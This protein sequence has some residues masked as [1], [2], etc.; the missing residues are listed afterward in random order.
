[1]ITSPRALFAACSVA[2]VLSLAA[3]AQTISPAPATAA[4][5]VEKPVTLSPFVLIEDQDGGYA[6]HETLSGTRLRTPVKDVASAMTIVTA[7][8]MRDLGALN[9]NDVLD[10]IPSTTTYTNNADDANSNGPRSG[11]PFVVRGYRSNSISTNFFTS[12][13]KPD[14]YNL[15]R[16]TFTRGPNS[17]LFS[18]GNPG[19]AIDGSTNRADVLRAFHSVELRGDSFDGFRSAIDSNLVIIPRK[20]ALRLDLLH[21][22]RGNHSFPA[23]DRRNSIFGTITAQ[24]AK[25][26]VLVANA[27]ATRLRQ[28]IPRPYETFDWVN[29]WIAAGRPLVP[30]AQRNTALNGVEFLAANGYPAYVPGSGAMDWARMGRGARPLVRGARQTVF[31]FGAGSP[32]RP[33]PLNRY[34]AGDAD[35]VDFN[36]ENYSLILQHRL[37]PGLNLELGA[38]HDRNDRENFDGNGM[39][40]AVEIDANAQLP[41]GQPN[42]NAGRPYTDQAPKLDRTNNETNQLRATLSYERDFSHLK[43]FNRGLGRFSLAALYNNEATHGTLETFTEVNVTPLPGSTPDLSD[44]RNNIRRRAYLGPGGPGYFTSD[45]APINENGIRSSW[46]QTRQPRND[47]TRVASLSIAGQANLLDNLLAITAGLRRDESQITQTNYV[48][49]ARGLYSSGARGG[50][51]LPRVEGVGRPYLLGAVL[52][53]HRNVSLYLN[54]AINYQA[55]SQG[56]RTFANEILPPVRGRGMDTG[57]KL[58]LWQDRLTGSFGYF[59]TSQQNIKDTAVTR[60]RKTGWINQ[61]W[62]TIDGSQRVDPAAGDVKDQRTQGLEFQVVANVTKN[63]RLM[64]NASRNVS[65]LEDQGSYTFRY[66]AQQYPSWTAQAARAVVSPDGRTVGDLVALIR[67]EESDDRRIVGIRQVRLHEWQAN[68]VGRYQFDRDSAL[69]GF[70]AGGAFRWRNAP[71]IGFARIGTVLDPTRPFRST[72]STNLDSFVEYA[73]PFTALGRKVR[74]SAQLRVQNLLDDRTLLPWIAEDDGTG[75]PIITQRLRPG[76]RQFVLSSAFAF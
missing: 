42:P 31:S 59:E 12:F 26:T 43:I 3:R 75:R 36:D 76:A 7:D 18:I 63:F 57:V 29:T 52:H 62:D 45:Y 25:D 34:I 54:K 11:T 39:G 66:L 32:N 16:L 35:R 22:D 71:V 8:L 47:F 27:E 58:S 20:L 19:G 72:P 6:P 40:F 1:M 10:F 4:T 53:A 38:S 67:Q 24:L 49:D 48:R 73:R 61:I 64:A 50:A 2:V 69:R 15:S 37:A 13:T 51:P 46:E 14:S 23:K 55:V 74:W 65:V 33:V 28:Q 60:G 70:A 17:I 30:V 56:V 21:D 44:A 5:A 9:Y 41:N 68:I